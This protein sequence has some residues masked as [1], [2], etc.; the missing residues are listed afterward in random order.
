MLWPVPGTIVY[1]WFLGFFRHKGIVSN[2]WWNGKP[3]VVASAQDSS[4]VAEVPW[5][6]FTGGKQA[7][8]EGYPSELPPHMVLYNARCLVGQAYDALTA[9]CEHFV[10]RCHGQQ[11]N[12][13]Q[14]AG[15]LALSFLGVLAA[16]AAR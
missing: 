13:P 7:F 6:T 1:V 15:V 14:V 12:S 10:Y 11:P 3:M 2:R 5:D 8:I 4:G 16:A 9:N